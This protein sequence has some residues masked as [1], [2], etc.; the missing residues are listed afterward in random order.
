MRP[1]RGRAGVRGVAVR[2]LARVE[3]GAFADRLLEA[4]LASLADPRD[5]ALLT[6]LVYG[7]LRWQGRLDHVLS[8]FAK[9]P[10]R[11]L[12]PEVRAA[13]RLAAY[14]LRHLDRIPAHAAVDEA[15]E[16][17]K[18]VA[19]GAAGFANALLRRVADEG[20]DVPL[21]A[22]P[23]ER[24]AVETSHPR[25]MVEREVAAHGVEEAARRLGADA[26]PA[27]LV[28]RA[29]EGVERLRA[30]L[31]AAGVAARPGRVAPDAVVI[32]PGSLPPGGVAALPGFAEG[33]F[34]VQDEASQLVARL[35]DPPTGA[36]VLDL[37]AAPGGKTGHLADLVGPHG[38]VVALD[39][40]PARLGRV[41]ETVARL[42]VADRVTVAAHDATTPL[43]AP[44]AGPYDAV[45]VDAPCSGLGVVR[46]NPDI[47]WRRR[48]EDV[49]PLAATQRAILEVAASAV[50]PGGRLV[51][52]VCTTTAEEGPG[53]V[54]GF[55]A[56]HPEYEA[57]A[58]LVTHPADGGLDGFFVQR[59]RRL[60]R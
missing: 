31:S 4:A 57:E 24:L 10:L 9:R 53:V 21:P 32:E 44:L 55:L 37:C 46:R 39:V 51:Y 42:G 58:R 41:R 33:A 27:P 14:Q 5:R 12:H 3:R 43:P 2:I 7:T 49:P 56:G 30:R 13:L 22:D 18:R 52:S 35:V 36:R 15:V 17:V 28:L 19:R 26:S 16:H 48:P 59:M 45:L 50:R 11:T 25:W 8:Y 54:D 47:L 6:E 23:I 1:P 60:V 29:R 40:D 38:R 20:G 34:A